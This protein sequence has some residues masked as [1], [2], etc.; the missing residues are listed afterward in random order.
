ML[1]LTK[2][3]I[4]FCIVYNLEYSSTGPTVIGNKGCGHVG[5]DCALCVR[6]ILVPM[7]YTYERP[8]KS[9]KNCTRTR[10]IILIIFSRGILL[11]LSPL[12]LV[13]TQSRVRCCIET[14]LK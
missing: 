3:A 4:L 5:D 6:R 13:Y 1:V 7:L 10:C 12:I 11:G 2:G 14:S 9:I 8:P